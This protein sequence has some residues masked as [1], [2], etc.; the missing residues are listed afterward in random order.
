MSDDSAGRLRLAISLVTAGAVLAACGSSGS[1]AP[2]EP[3]PGGAS[4]GSTA[5]GSAATSAATSKTVAAAGGSGSV[6][7][8]GLLSA[9]QAS[10][11]NN[12]TYGAATPKMITSGWDECSYTNTGTHADPVDIQP[13]EVSVLNLPGCWTALHQGK[14]NTSPVPG[15]GDEA[16]GYEIGL[17]VKVGSR[18][19]EV[20]GLTHAEL[21]GDYSHDAAM[22]KIVIGHLS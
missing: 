3:S 10:S 4:G 20:E 2:P 5:A 13:L 16:F 9:A 17:A 22:A 7:V 8:C 21:I 1:A 11:I 15:I 6:D 14:S 12:V 18:C 19:I